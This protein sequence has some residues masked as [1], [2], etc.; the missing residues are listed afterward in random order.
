MPPERYQNTEPV[1]LEEVEYWSCDQCSTEVDESEQPYQEA[2]CCP[3]T[4][5]PICD[6]CAESVISCYNCGDEMYDEEATYSD[7]EGEYYC[8]D[9]YY[10]EFAR[11]V[12]CD[13]EFP[14]DELTYD[15][16]SA[17]YYCDDC[18]STNPGWFEVQDYVDNLRI[19]V[20]E[21]A[22][23]VDDTPPVCEHMQDIHGDTLIPRYKSPNSYALIR[24]KRYVGIEVE[25]YNPHNSDDVI[26]NVRRSMKTKQQTHYNE[27]ISSTHDYLTHDGSL[28][29]AN[30]HGDE[31]AGVELVMSPRRGD[32]LWKDIG[33]IS[34]SLRQDNGRVDV[35]TGQHMHIDSRD[36]DWYHRLLL[37]AVVKMIEP[38][39]FA[40]LPPSRK[41]SRYCRPVGQAWWQ[42][43]NIRNRSDFMAFWYHDTRYSDNR[44]ND[45]RYD[46]L[47]MHTGLRESGTGSIEIRYH[48][49]TLNP[50]KMRAWAIFWTCL[51]DYTKE[52]ANE[53][54]S[55]YGKDRFS[56]ALTEFYI[57]GTNTGFRSTIQKANMPD[58]QSM[59]W[60]D[61]IAYDREHIPTECISGLYRLIGQLARYNLTS[62]EYNHA[63]VIGKKRVSS[64]I[65]QKRA[66]RGRI[67]SRWQNDFRPTM[68]MQQL[69][70]E[71][72]MPGWV[73][74]NFANRSLDRI[75]SANTPDSFLSSCLRG[76]NAVVE[77][78]E[79]GFQTRHVECPYRVGMQTNVGS[80]E[81]F[82][83]SPEANV[84]FESDY[85]LGISIVKS[86]LLFSDSFTNL[87]TA[88][89]RIN[90]SE[91]RNFSYDYLVDTALNRE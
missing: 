29:R 4:A 61:V 77:L 48:S 32:Y 37:T 14:L 63:E 21:Y 66:F 87:Y 34:K 17:E 5:L 47:N 44:Y 57:G 13:N 79:N 78:T 30:N 90:Y 43:N 10:D 76:L 64:L 31:Y 27:L 86:S 22:V 28:V 74:D 83:N 20:P 85:G 46:G 23:W 49:G 65:E 50:E 54:Y 60:Y 82:N 75:Q 52:I 56:N 42:F 25:H 40:M 12:D 84:F 45:K 88:L 26:M 35:S 68:N 67:L 39:L 6:G 69:M 55:E 51:V 80:D 36:L 1:E 89:R 73:I 8:E 53:M 11:C 33:Y 70:L 18:C 9:C 7:Y 72:K 38:H 24:S 2:T 71:C 59:D 91:N 15:D 19:A 81:Q 62:V 3:S 41:N 58:F 16:D